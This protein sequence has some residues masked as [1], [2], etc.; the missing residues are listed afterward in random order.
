MNDAYHKGRGAQINTKNR[1][2]SREFVKEHIEGI[3]EDSGPNH[4]RKVFYESPKTILS[5]NNSPDIP[6][7][8]SI[9][10][11]QGCEH[12][13]VYCYARNTHSYWG[14][15]AGMDWESKII[16]KMDA[17]KMLEKVFLK[18]SWKPET[19]MLSGNTDPYQPLEKKLKI[20]RSL[21]GVFSRYHNPVGIITKN[22][23]IARDLDILKYLAELRLVRIYFSVTTMDEKLRR[24]MEPRTAN[25]MKMMK[26]IQLFAKEGIETGVLMGPIIPSI[27]DH[28]ID[29]ILRISAEHGASSA[30]F[31]LARFN[32]DVSAIFAD[33]LKRNYSDRALK[34]W[35][36][37]KSMHGGKVS[38]SRFGTRMKGEG[39][40]AEM[41]RGVFHASR[42][43][44]FKEAQ[45]SKLRKDLFRVNGNLHLFF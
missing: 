24:I 8:Y 3:D 39:N 28:E 41:I 34:V 44:Y 22:S 9:N 16:V 14:F 32:G 2:L 43:K 23:L 15:S 1:F 35:N 36:K 4:I 18:K 11:Y 42:K 21:L 31:T 40:Y 26:T 30:S 27:N 25:A 17:A 20:T 33:W 45:S 10:P 37:V 19:I 13:C 12:G 7:R 38:D 5:E 6:F 29:D